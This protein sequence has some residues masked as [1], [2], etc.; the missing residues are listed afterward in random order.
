MDLIHNPVQ[1]VITGT[2][3]EA[4]TDA[5][6]GEVHKAGRLDLVL[7]VIAE[8]ASLPPGH[9]ATGKGAV[10]GKATA[11]VCNGPVCSL[12][13]SD[14]AALADLLEGAGRA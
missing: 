7:Q 10:D 12:P 14:A 9:P 1:V 5:L 6:I 8:G 2:R 4:A 11:Y 13:V 3:G